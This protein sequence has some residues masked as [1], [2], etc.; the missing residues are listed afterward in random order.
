V[1]DRSDGPHE[2]VPAAGFSVR[3]YARTAAGSHRDE[4]DLA[5][6]ADR[7]LTPATLRALRFL[8]ASESGTMG[9]LRNVLVTAT[10]KDARVTAFLGTWAFEK[11][12]I[13]DAIEQV[14]AAHDEARVPPA[15]APTRLAAF[16]A[17]VRERVRPITGSITA[18]RLGEDMVAVHMASGAIDEWLSQAALERVVELDPHPALRPI[19]DRL[20]DVKRRQLEFFEAQALDRLAGARTRSVVRRRLRGT[21]WPI[22]ARSGPVS[23]SLF[24]YEYLFSGAPAAVRAIDATIDTL[25]GQEGLTL[26]SR[27]V[28]QHQRV[29]S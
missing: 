26:I 7:P 18:S 12:W 4:I 22:G 5:P 17:E 25:P 8:A 24:F 27:A 10:H 14:V 2:A 3:D 1:R 21:R 15:A 9:H 29:S 13:A 23:E 11:F 6:F 16:A 19:V 28:P 20:L